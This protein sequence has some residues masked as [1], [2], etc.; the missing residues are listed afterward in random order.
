[1]IEA[2]GFLGGCLGDPMAT[3]R[4][5]VVSETP[6]PGAELK[7]VVFTRDCGATTGSGTHVSVLPYRAALSPRDEGNIFI[8]E[9]EDVHVEWVGRNRLRLGPDPRAHVFKAKKLVAGVRIEYP[10]PTG[11]GD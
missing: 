1:M 6:S 10:A 7:A 3:C 9:S 11:D 2:S 4:N 8:M 5:S